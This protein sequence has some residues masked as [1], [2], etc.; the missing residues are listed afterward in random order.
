VQQVGLGLLLDAEI[1]AAGLEAR[2][3]FGQLGGR[4]LHGRALDPGND[5]RLCEYI[6][7]EAK[8][9]INE[10][11]TESAEHQQRPDQ[12]TEPERDV[13]EPALARI[14]PRIH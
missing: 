3:Q 11:D 4:K 9:H 10:R 6:A 7:D 2:M 5:G 14:N 12:K 13:A 1:A 8:Q